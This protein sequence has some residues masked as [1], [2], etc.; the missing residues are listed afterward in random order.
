MESNDL[1]KRKCVDCGAQ[2]T[3]EDVMKIITED[4]KCEIFPFSTCPECFKEN[5]MK[6]KNHKE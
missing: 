3:E 2:L 1:D 6:T 5:L 4:G